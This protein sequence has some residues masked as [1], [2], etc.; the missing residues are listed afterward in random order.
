MKIKNLYILTSLAWT[1]IVSLSFTWNYHEASKEQEKVALE[2]SRTFFEYI[3]ITRIWNARHAGIYVPITE[4]TQ[5]NPYLEDPLRELKISDQLTLTKI[6][7]AYMTR[8]IAEIATQR[9]GVQFHMSSLNPI[10]PNN[11]PSKLEKK[12]LL[13]FEN[14]LRE[15]GM[16]INENNQKYYFYMAPL[17]TTQSC[18]VCHAKQGY[19]D[20]DVR[21]AISVTYPYLMQFPYLTLLVGHLLIGLTGLIL[22]FIANK[23]LTK[24]YQ[25]IQKQAIFDEVT[26]IPNRRSF[27]ERFENEFKRHSRDQQ[28]LSLIMA[29]ID[30]FK[31]FNDTYGHLSGDNCLNRVAQTIQKTLKRPSDFCARYGGEEFVILLPDT[32]MK[33]AEQLAEKLRA[34][35]EALNI[36]NKNAKHAQVVTISLGV[37]TL[38]ENN[39]LESDEAL[40]KQADDALYQAK[41]SGRNQVQ[42]FNTQ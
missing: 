26:E 25:I 4:E 15:K 39:L 2:S 12:I 24:A 9:D 8:Q 16:F 27:S 21:G 19:K 38:T 28:P 13:E 20:G 33:G 30:K 14:G 6:N 23:K 5:P 37:A 3:T 36:S 41:E 1:I 35:I 40:I 22:I 17:M 11:Q 18:L 7:P 10:N 29:D 34:N 31:I 42:I 32:E